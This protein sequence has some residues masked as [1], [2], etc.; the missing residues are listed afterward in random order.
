MQPIQ[1]ENQ[2]AINNLVNL[3]KTD[4]L[5]ANAMKDLAMI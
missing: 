1:Q 2:R 4:P 5:L 3:A